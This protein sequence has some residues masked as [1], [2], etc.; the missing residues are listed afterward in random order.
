VGGTLEPA[1]GGP[2]PHAAGTL[3][4]TN[5]HIREELAGLMEPGER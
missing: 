1:L 5:G 2:W 3:L 4:V